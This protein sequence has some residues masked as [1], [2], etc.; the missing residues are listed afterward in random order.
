MPSDSV[1]SR[2]HRYAGMVIE[3]FL[4]DIWIDVAMLRGPDQEGNA[5]LRWG[6]FVTALGHYHHDHA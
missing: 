2:H 5:R 4:A 1:V 6:E 3:P